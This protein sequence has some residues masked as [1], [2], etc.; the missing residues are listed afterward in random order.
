M[1]THPI[2]VP[3][4]SYRG[5][6]RAIAQKVAARNQLAQRLEEYLNA[7]IAKQ[8]EPYQA[9]F[10]YE[11]AWALNLRVEDVREILFGIDA[12]HGGFTVYMPPERRAALPG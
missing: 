10:Y 1:V 7:R 3:R 8:T 6:K 4:K 12:G 2:R 9:Y 5:S 11:I